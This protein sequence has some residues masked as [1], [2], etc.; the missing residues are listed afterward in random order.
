MKF[1]LT[2]HYNIEIWVWSLLFN[3]KNASEWRNETEKKKIVRERK[4]VTKVLID[5]LFQ[6]LYAFVSVCVRHLLKRSF[7]LTQT[8]A[9]NLNTRITIC[10]Y[11]FCDGETEK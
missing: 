1:Q 11:A 6:S 7:G 4:K 10:V 5:Y 9:T 3:M 2:L 8:N